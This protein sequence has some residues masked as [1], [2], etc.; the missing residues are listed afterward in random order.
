MYS[1]SKFNKVKK[2]IKSSK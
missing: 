2:L 1:W